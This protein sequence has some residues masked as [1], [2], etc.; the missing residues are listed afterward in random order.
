MSVSFQSTCNQVG[1]Q[2]TCDQVGFQSTCN[3]VG[4]QST[5][6]Q[7]GFPS[8]CNQ[9]GFQSTCNQ[10][11]FQSTCNQVGFQSTCNQVGFHTRHK[12]NISLKEY[13]KERQ[14]LQLRQRWDPELPDPTQ[15]LSRI[16]QLVAYFELLIWNHWFYGV[17]H[18]RSPSQPPNA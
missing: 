9:V 3:Q 8:T 2:S 18:N 12:E 10:V 1:F 7:V 16:S 13:C 17:G 15:P 6:N 11:G 14:L 4:F 5:C